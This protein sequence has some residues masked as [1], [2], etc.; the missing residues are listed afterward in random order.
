MAPVGDLVDAD[1]G[2]PLHARTVRSPTPADARRGRLRPHGR[3]SARSSVDEHQTRHLARPVASVHRHDVGRTRTPDR[4]ALDD[5]RYRN[6]AARAKVVFSTVPRF[7][8]I[9]TASPTAGCVTLDSCRPM[10]KR[11]RSSSVR[12]T[13]SR[14]VVGACAERLADRASGGDHRK[15]HRNRSSDSARG[16][17]VARRPDRRRSSDPRA[18]VSGGRRPVSYLRATTRTRKGRD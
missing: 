5:R 2:Q 15:R 1:A 13:N 7:Q 10:G 4:T 6:E 3:R 17:V 16:S 18:A 9:A 12:G 11:R 8:Q 14:S